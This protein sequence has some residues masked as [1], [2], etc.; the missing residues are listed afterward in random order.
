MKV[1]VLMA[2]FLRD[3]NNIKIYNRFIQN[4]SKHD[5][6]TFMYI[7]DKLGESRPYNGYNPEKR[8]I[9]TKIIKEEDIKNWNPKIFEIV[10]FENKIKEI[11]NM[12]KDINYDKKQVFKTYSQFHMLYNCY[13]LLEKYIKQNNMKYDMII[14]LRSDIYYHTMIIDNI[15]INN[16]INLF[17]RGTI[18]YDDITLFYASDMI[19]YGNI[20]MMEKYC[21]LGDINTFKYCSKIAKYIC[22]N[23]DKV[24]VKGGACHLMFV[25]ELLLTINLNYYNIS[26]YKH[27]VYYEMI[28]SNPEKL[29]FII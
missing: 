2:G 26:I 14:R 10:N 24:I 25:G 4:N 23:K 8:I 9:N 11:N 21:K 28:R 5:I 13:L 20:N 7:Y 27:Q 18:K 6:D 15:K 29:K 12:I 19:S 16:S 17:I 22:E 3:T 1:A